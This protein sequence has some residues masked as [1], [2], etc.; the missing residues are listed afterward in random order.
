MA[1]LAFTAAALASGTPHDHLFRCTSPELATPSHHAR[2]LH[3]ALHHSATVRHVDGSSSPALEVA[4]VSR[5]SAS[6][7]RLLE[8]S[9]AGQIS[10]MACNDTHV[11]IDTRTPRGA[12]HI[13][14]LLLPGSVVTGACTSAEEGDPRPFYRRV[15]AATCGDS[16]HGIAAGACTRLVVATAEATL[17]DAFESLTLEV[18][19]RPRAVQAR[20]P[21]LGS[22]DDDGGGGGGG[23]ARPRRRL[24]LDAIGD[25]GNYIGEGLVS[26]GGDLIEGAGDCNLPNTRGC[27]PWDDQSPRGI[28]TRRRR[29]RAK[30][31]RR[32]RPRA[33]RCATR[34]YDEVLR[35]R[36]GAYCCDH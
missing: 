13:R 20:P 25:V 16:A 27:G 24:F 19:A 26:I 29:C 28:R 33:A 31:R 9:L 15:R 11:R 6:A 21:P 1:M 4:Y 12:D 23:D 18:Q 35:R 8:P 32:R 30:P 14:D 5:A 3:E 36:D 2:A 7:V 34:E 17:H 10:A 22:G